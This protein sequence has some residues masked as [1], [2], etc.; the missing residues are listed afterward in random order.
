[1]ANS[2]STK[3]NGRSRG[4]R[5]APAPRGVSVG[6]LIALSVSLVLILLLSH[7]GW[8]PVSEQ[9]AENM[10]EL[11]LDHFLIDRSAGLTLSHFLTLALALCVVW[12]G[13][14]VITLIL[15]AVGRRDDR[16]ATITHL[17]CGML[18]YLAVIIAVMWGL[19]ILGVN[20]TAVLAGVGIIGL[21]LGFG[22]QSLIEDI[23]TGFFIIFEGQYSIGDIIILDDFRGVVRDI[24]VRTTVIEDDGGN[25]K[26][27]NNSDIR[28]F[29]NRSR[30]NSLAIC[31]VGVSYSTD[32][33]ALEKMLEPE[34]PAM[35]ERNKDLYL[36]PPR[37]YGVEELG[38]NGVT[39]KIVVP[40]KES[41]VFA[42][43][44]RG[45]P[46]PQSGHTRAVRTEGYRD[47][48]P[49]GRGAP[50]RLMPGCSK[51]S[52]LFTRTF[53][54]RGFCLRLSYALL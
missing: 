12:F 9:T 29:Q 20:M 17:L 47:P 28:N 44:L 43:G 34:L 19:S 32:L 21:V 8:L 49:P 2:T 24:G 15:R 23:I 51:N 45:A 4:A 50:G 37:Y 39:L 16:A 54:Q 46:P 3:R 38:D 41:T 42:Y 40:T 25:L 33:M 13:Y 53:V 1:M 27:V 48:L 14:T 11:R 52:L 18:K 5:R 26:V 10:E 22:A 36:G 31:L 30:V 7:P 35:Y 6:M